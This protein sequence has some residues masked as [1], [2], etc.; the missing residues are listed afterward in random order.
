M[1]T[2]EEVQEKIAKHQLGYASHYRQ[3][4]DTE[5]GKKV[6]F[7]LADRIG[8][9][10]SMFEKDTN[11]MYFKA[12]RREVLFFIFKMLEVDPHTYFEKF[13]QQREVED[14]GTY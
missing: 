9:Y 11:R 2:N 10:S 12:G 4:F 13:K 5:S 1:A 8:L 14:Y 7:D 6:L 3:V